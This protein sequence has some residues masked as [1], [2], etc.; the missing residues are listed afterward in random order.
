MSKKTYEDAIKIV[1]KMA[2]EIHN[3]VEDDAEWNSPR[4]NGTNCCE[5]EETIESVL[6]NL[7]AGKFKSFYKS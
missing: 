5:A 3:C 2:A 4:G 7:R 1:E 6:D